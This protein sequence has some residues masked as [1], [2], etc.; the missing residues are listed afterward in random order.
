M[1]EKKNGRRSTR[2]EDR[3]SKASAIIAALPQA[4]A[5]DT[6]S[7]TDT[8]NEIAVPVPTEDE[9]SNPATTVQF[10]LKEELRV[11]RQQ[12]AE[13]TAQYRESVGKK[14]SGKSETVTKVLAMLEEGEGA[15]KEN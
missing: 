8:S 9:Q 4:A 10:V 15:T 14:P 3:A 2:A 6:P 5:S 11:L 7:L 13:K 1:A 12:L